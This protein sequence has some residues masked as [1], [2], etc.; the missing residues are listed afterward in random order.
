MAADPYLEAVE[1]LTTAMAMLTSKLAAATQPP[2]PTGP[3]PA[4]RE[5]AE[6]APE[7]S[8]IHQ[9]G[10]RF[11]ASTAGGLANRI[12]G[13]YGAAMG[14]NLGGMVAGK[15][16]SMFGPKGG[17][18]GGGDGGVAAQPPPAA[19]MQQWVARHIQIT[20]EIVNVTTKGGVGGDTK[21]K[22]AMKMAGKAEGAGGEGGV[23]A[24]GEGEAAAAGMGGRAAGAVAAA[25]PF[26]VVAAAVL[27]AVLALKV[28]HDIVVKNAKAQ[29]NLN[30]QYA[31]VSAAMAGVKVHFEIADI[32]RNRE[33]GDK[34]AGTASVLSD[35]NTRYDDNAAQ[36]EMLW[37]NIKNLGLAV[38]LESINSAIQ[39]LA[40]VATQI[41]DRIL[42]LTET[43]EEKEERERRE[44]E[45]GTFLANA[46]KEAEKR[47]AAGDEWFKR[48]KAPN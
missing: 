35:S 26:A 21:A 6:R 23:A 30:F 33:I 4:P 32:M 3:P 1:K 16:G 47:K 12:G 2:T 24:A 28:F 7:P 8:A 29:Q 44:M 19:P 25:G 37:S 17:G 42:K 10:T 22:D 18:Q 48:F 39:P 5:Q 9:W 15:V 43:K 36:F 34:T 27:A 41:N 38:L 11:L 45:A 40:Q 31:D 46:R 20:A 14:L 13:R